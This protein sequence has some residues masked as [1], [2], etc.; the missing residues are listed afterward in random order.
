[1]STR[2]LKSYLLCNYRVLLAQGRCNEGRISVPDL[3]LPFELRLTN[4]LTKAALCHDLSWTE[5]DAILLTLEHYGWVAE[6]SSWAF[7]LSLRD[8]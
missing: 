5:V 3:S 2:T 7:Y 4:V 1:M 6:E 8:G